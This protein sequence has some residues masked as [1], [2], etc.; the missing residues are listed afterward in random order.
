MHICRDVDGNYAVYRRTVL[1]GD[2]GRDIEAA[3][4][5]RRGEI[6]P[7]PQPE[8]TTSSHGSVGDNKRTTKRQPRAKVLPAPKPP[9]R[10]TKGRRA[11][12][13]L[14]SV[15]L[16]PNMVPILQT[17][18][19]KT[20]SRNGLPIASSHRPCPARTDKISA[21]SSL[22]QASSS[23]TSSRPTAAPQ[24]RSKRQSEQSDVASNGKRLKVHVYPLENPLL[25]TSQTQALATAL[26]EHMPRDRFLKLMGTVYD[27]TMP[28]VK[29]V[30]R[31]GLEVLGDGASTTTKG[32]VESL[33]RI[34]SAA[35]VHSGEDRG[36]T[37]TSKRKDVSSTR[38]S[39]GSVTSKAA[40][41]TAVE[42]PLPPP[43]Q[44]KATVI[45]RSSS[46]SSVNSAKQDDDH[47]DKS[48]LSEMTVTRLP[49]PVIPKDWKYVLGVHRAVSL[50]G[51][52]RFSS[53]MDAV[54]AVRASQLALGFVPSGVAG[55]AKKADA[56]RLT[57]AFSRIHNEVTK[58]GCTWHARITS[59]GLLADFDWYHNH[60]AQSE[61][62]ISRR[63]V[64]RNW[65]VDA[66]I[67][68]LRKRGV[69][70]SG[71]VDE[72]AQEVTR[73]VHQM[74]PDVELSDSEY[75]RIASELCVVDYSDDDC[76]EV[77]EEKNEAAEIND[78]GKD[79]EDGTEADNE[80]DLDDGVDVDVAAMNAAASEAYRK[81]THEAHSEHASAIE[82][83]TAPDKPKVV[84]DVE[85][86]DREMCIANGGDD[87]ENCFDGGKDGN[88]SDR[89]S[90]SDEGGDF[91]SKR[92]IDRK[93][94]AAVF[95]DED[96]SDA[97]STLS[98]SKQA[99]D[100]SDLFSESI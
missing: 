16:P 8:P 19:P 2:S 27:L 59:E 61:A 92:V 20:V 31:D 62:E 88:M 67:L 55:A 17:E 23:I 5:I 48:A 69:S 6:G 73:I 97:R 49:D 65:V 11:S 72:T 47:R 32:I 15:V 42:V 28:L 63:S 22:S 98:G 40:I 41:L 76:A 34:M 33:V 83:T 35:V 18:S 89:S 38:S 24:M 43:V 90:S 77:E 57:C 80:D 7:M 45:R 58:S 96:L 85:D 95:D 91:L 9:S 99:E 3:E 14:T 1:F 74:L 56:V 64:V 10:E 87:E 84:M 75:A 25:A 39:S 100:L 53:C 4:W 70:L 13:T 82:K 68:K 26:A 30:A 50:H 54:N 81:N 60:D 36:R 44:R 71:S 93:K 21:R 51:G 29:S 78:Q 46:S 79:E 86:S 37:G 52:M 12:S 94:L 66:I